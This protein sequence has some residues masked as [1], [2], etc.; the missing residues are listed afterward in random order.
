MMAEYS[1]AQKTVS[2]QVFGALVTYSAITFT[3]SSGDPETHHI[4]PVPTM[5][6]TLTNVSNDTPNSKISALSTLLGR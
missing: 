4:T 6:L 2:L 3:F 1:F 5:S